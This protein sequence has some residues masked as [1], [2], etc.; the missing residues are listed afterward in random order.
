MYP[1]RDLV[2]GQALSEHSGGVLGSG[3]AVSEKPGLGAAI[4]LLM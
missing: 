4:Q 2:E 3:Q 1:I